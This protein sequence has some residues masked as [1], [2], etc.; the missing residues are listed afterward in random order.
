MNVS[1]TPA[2]EAFIAEKV[3][4]GAYGSTSEVVRAGLR[5][6]QQWHAEQDAKLEALRREIAMGDADF[7][8]GRVV[9]GPEF[10]KTLLEKAR[11]RTKSADTH[12]RGRPKPD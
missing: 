9:D 1:V 2:L 5:C 4:S 10:M 7:E 6:L 3:A 11:A 8:A 12:K